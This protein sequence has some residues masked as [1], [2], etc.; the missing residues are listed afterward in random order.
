M[1]KELT[2]E[3]LM[4]KAPDYTINWDAIIEMWPILA[5]LENVDQSPIYHK[6][7]NVLIHTKMVLE[8]LVGN[9]EWRDIADEPKMTLFLAAIFHDLGKL[10][11]T[12]YENGNITS[13]GHSAAG[14]RMA[15]KC[16]SN[17]DLGLMN[18]NKK[19][20][21]IPWQMREDVCTLTL[22]HL[23]P[24]YLVDHKDP[25]SFVTSS[26]WTLRNDYL[27]ILCEA[28]GLGRITEGYSD[29]LERL[30]LFESFCE[31]NGCYD[32]KKLFQTDE[33]RFRY[34][35]ERKGHPDFHIYDDTVGTVYMMSG[36][37]GSGK[38]T[39]ANEQYSQYPMVSLDNIRKE[40]GIKSLDNQGPVLRKA[41]EDCKVQM[42]LKADFVFN[43]TNITK[44]TR[45]KWIRL[46]RKYKYK[47]CIIY[48]EP[49]FD[50]ILKQNNSRDDAIPEHAVRKMFKDLDPPTYL[51]CHDLI[52]FV[53]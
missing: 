2:I 3:D 14:A 41:K 13:K 50:V 48:V 45:A 8:C 18:G 21:I 42:R 11:A 17:Y 40:I 19:A 15:R 53:Y 24:F 36:V 37:A 32:T 29:A 12:K 16:L 25:V 34:F 5:S 20:P 1:N 47:I 35:F 44:H 26:S 6:E 38:D 31:E 10:T 43:A 49:T 27:R 30:D 39:V 33:T 9:L 46:F 52:H 4:P 7:G 22:L 51:E 28:D 23:N